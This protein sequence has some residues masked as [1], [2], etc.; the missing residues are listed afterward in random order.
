MDGREESNRIELEIKS[1]NETHKWT[2]RVRTNA[3][4][5]RERKDNKIKKKWEKES[6]PE[7]LD[8]GIPK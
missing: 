8:Y 5:T 3:Q 2:K 1:H 4:N 7:T 6:E